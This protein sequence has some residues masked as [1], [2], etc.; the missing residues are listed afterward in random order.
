MSGDR[1]SMVVQYSPEN[2][3]F[4]DTYYG[5]VYR[6]DWLSIWVFKYIGYF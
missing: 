1:A 3:C 6:V 5:P 4:L 2:R